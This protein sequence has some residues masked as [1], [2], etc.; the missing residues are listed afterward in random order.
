MRAR[1]GGPGCRVIAPISFFFLMIR[2]PP[3]ST[4]FPYTTL[5]R[6]LEA[7]DVHRRDLS[8]AGVFAA[9]MAD[10]RHPFGSPRLGHR[11]LVR[12]PLPDL[13]PQ[14]VGRAVLLWRHV[15][16]DRS[17]RGHGHRAATGSPVSH[18]ELR[19]LCAKGPVARP[20]V[21]KT[22]GAPPDGKS[23]EQLDRAV[24]FLGP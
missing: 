24:I 8:G 4:L 7:S 2:R 13:V 18:A 6:S 16:A 12:S 20:A 19:G 10:H 22:S 23:V 21:M 3:R 1:A 11:R 9:G 15:P 14:G 17:R 5:F